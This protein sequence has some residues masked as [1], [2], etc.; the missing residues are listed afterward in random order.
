MEVSRGSETPMAGKGMRTGAPCLFKPR[1]SV[2]CSL[3]WNA[4]L[5]NTQGTEQDTNPFLSL[6]PSVGI[7]PQ[8]C[9]VDAVCS[10]C[11]PLSLLVTHVLWPVHCLPS[12]LL[13]SPFCDVYCSTSPALPS[14]SPCPAL[15]FSQALLPFHRVFA[16]LFVHYLSPPRT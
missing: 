9:N 12:Y 10:F 4:I 3:K 1:G 15:F 7:F 5:S 8:A 11:L 6:L 13:R 2:F 14:W 16:S